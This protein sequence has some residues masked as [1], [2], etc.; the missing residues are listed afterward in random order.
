MNNSTETE[1]NY[2]LSIAID[3]YYNPQFEELEHNVS[4]LKNLFSTLISKY[5]FEEDNIYT[6]HD[7][8]ATQSEIDNVI[9]SFQKD[10]KA[11]D[12]LLIFFSGHG[13][14]KL[15]HGYFILHDGNEYPF[16]EILKSIKSL[17]EFK[18]IILFL[19]CC[20]SG[21]I[22]SETLN[23]GG[24]NFEL[25]TPKCRKAIASNLGDRK[26]FDDSPFINSITKFLKENE[27]SDKISTD[28]IFSKI[29]YAMNSAEPPSEKR[30]GKIIH[31]EGG[32]FYFKLKENEEKIWLKTKSEDTIEGY[33]IYLKSFSRNEVEAN[34]RI[35]ELKYQ[36][37]KW[38]EFLEQVNNNFH[39]IEQNSFAKEYSIKILEF[40]NE[41][42]N[43]YRDLKFEQDSNKA[44]YGLNQTNINEV[45]NFISRFKKSKFYKV[46]NILLT[47]LEKE[48]RDKNEWEAIELKANRRSIKFEETKKDYALYLRERNKNNT[49]YTIAEKKFEDVLKYLEAINSEDDDIRKKKLNEYI[50]SSAEFKSYEK[51]ARIELG[52]L[53]TEIYRK[54]DEEN[55]HKLLDQKSIS[56][57]LYFIETR[58][59]DDFS[60]K[61]QSFINDIKNQFSSLFEEARLSD[62]V[63]QIETAI[64][65]FDNYKD[66]SDYNESLKKILKEKDQEMYSLT[67]SIEGCENY[68]NEFETNQIGMFVTVVKSKLEKFKTEKLKFEDI[69]KERLSNLTKTVEL[70]ESYLSH[71]QDRFYFSEINEIKLEVEK[72]ISDEAMFSEISKEFTISNCKEYL[73]EFG[74]TKHKTLVEEKLKILTRD[75]A[76]QDA[77][78]EIYIQNEKRELSI[79]DLIKLCK[80]YRNDSEKDIFKFEVDV[81]LEELLTDQTEENDFEDMKKEGSIENV[82]KFIEKYIKGKKKQEAEKFLNDLERDEQIRKEEMEVDNNDYLEAI[83]IY[84]EDSFHNYQEKHPNGLN[85]SGANANIK[86]LQL[87]ARD[88]EEFEM[89]KS[90]NTIERFK[91]YLLKFDLPRYA[92]EAHENIK[93]LEWLKLDKETFEDARLKNNVDAF[94]GYNNKFGKEGLFF[95]DAIINIANISGFID[96][97][98]DI[99]EK[100]SDRSKENEWLKPPTILHI[101]TIIILIIVV[102]LM[103]R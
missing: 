41:F 16:T 92:K 29:S 80:N 6:L 68:L 52:R 96:L 74:F 33:S 22:F 62:S 59:D 40:R 99:L 8:F 63:N 66:A 102:Y 57:L 34:I 89:A 84:S 28:E 14:I 18:N 37:S 17:K 85:V 86:N 44:W 32:E 20:N 97:K 42:Y 82:K 70:C 95:K 65:Y 7:N 87:I 4:N 100:K 67:N 91:S 78:N 19:N 27:N 49:Y 21:N 3:K 88:N 36:E 26:S 98:Q 13:N 54:K 39:E 55:I 12:S 93:K 23:Q 30:S 10:A 15:D 53:E 73:Y 83:K 25:L 48:E 5:D 45:E 58:D 101:L 71:S 43:I 51:Y 76:D 38:L 79:E 75:K 11:D 46:A 94:N 50:K 77:Y 103:K 72:E 90:L 35:K 24:V 64:N 47:K 31:D 81:I 56:G 69:K 61:A 2:V 9:R 60:K 1:K